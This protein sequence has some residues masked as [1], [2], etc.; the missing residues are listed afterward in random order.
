MIRSGKIWAVILWKCFCLPLSLLSFW[1]SSDSYYLDW[2]ILFHRSLPL[3]FLYKSFIHIFF[4]LDSVYCCFLKLTALFFYS[5]WSDLLW[6][7]SSVVLFQVFYFSSPKFPFFFFFGSPISFFKF[8]FSCVLEKMAH[9]YICH[10]SLLVRWCKMLSI[11]HFREQLLL[12]FFFIFCF[13]A[14]L[15]AFI[16]CRTLTILFGVLNFVLFF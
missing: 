12:N 8:I 6:I 16:A 11:S 10:F 1:N 5:I 15:I 4:L 9:I 14:Y 7:S 13:F 2:F 3:L